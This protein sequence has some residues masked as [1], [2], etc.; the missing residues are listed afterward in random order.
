MFGTHKQIILANFTNV[1]S[2][3]VQQIRKLLRSYDS[4]LII[5]KNTLT[6]KVINMR[7][8]GIEEEEFKYLEE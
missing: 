7:T 8:Q 6:K 1:G 5:N 3:Q 4:H 2:N